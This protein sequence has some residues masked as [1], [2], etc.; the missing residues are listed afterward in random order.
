MVDIAHIAINYAILFGFILTFCLLF[1]SAICCCMGCRKND[2]T[3]NEK[4]KYFKKRF[5]VIKYNTVYTSDRAG[6]VST[7]RGANTGNKSFGI[8]KDIASKLDAVEKTKKNTTR[9]ASPMTPCSFDQYNVPTE[10]NA[11]KKETNQ[12]I[13]DQKDKIE[14]KENKCSIVIDDFS[15]THVRSEKDV[16]PTRGSGSVSPTKIHQEIRIHSPAKYDGEC[17]GHKEVRGISTQNDDV[18]ALDKE[19]KI[20][21]HYSFDNMNEEDDNSATTV[22]GNINDESKNVFRDLEAFVN[23][24]LKTMD[25]NEV[26]ILLKIS[27]PGGYAYKFELAYTH[28]LRL[29]DTGFHMIALVDD[30]CASGGY[31]LA[32]ACHT[33][34][35]SEYANIGSIGVTTSLYNYYGLCQKIG[36]VEK[37]LTTGPYKRPF[38]AGEPF[39]QKDVDRV[40]ELI[41]D[42]LV[43]FKDIVQKSRSLTDE[44]MKELLSARVWYGRKALEKKMVDVI[45]SSNEYLDYLDKDKNQIFL[46]CRRLTKNKT[47]LQS[48]FEM[49]VNHIQIHA[50]QLIAKLTNSMIKNMGT[51]RQNIYMNNYSDDHFHKIL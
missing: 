1:L 26:V 29:R 5:D 32:S 42:S 22:L 18:N 14:R 48:L 3:V 15:N 23:I 41:N 7:I 27:S 47:S 37:T 20:Y 50:P 44:E 25:P 43:V 21:L 39:E 46:V 16:S 10:K 35:C 36:L 28:L 38:P 4:N 8:D 13:V 31:M 12:S 34:V 6:M 19:A 9:N 33:I 51:T 24:V 45:M 17:V 30:I 11:K 49:S 2:D 40:D